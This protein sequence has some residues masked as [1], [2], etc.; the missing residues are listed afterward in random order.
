MIRQKALKGQ[1][2]QKTKKKNKN[3][4]QTFGTLRAKRFKRFLKKKIR[5]QQF[6]VLRSSE[7]FCLTI[8]L[9]TAF[10]NDRRWI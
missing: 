3:S 7:S 9:K 8:I 5:V 2:Q 10:K 4:T 6:G 1:I